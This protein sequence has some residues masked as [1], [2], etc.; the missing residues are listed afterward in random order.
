M[1]SRILSLTVGGKL[2]WFQ[3]VREDYLFHTQPFYPF[4]HLSHLHHPY[5][6]LSFE[7]FWDIC[8]LWEVTCLYFYDWKLMLFIVKYFKYPENGKNN[9]INSTCLLASSRESEHFTSFALVLFS[10]WE[11]KIFW[12][13]LKS[14]VYTCLISSPCFSL[15]DNYHPEFDVCLSVHVITQLSSM[16]TYSY[17]YRY[18][19]LKYL[20]SGL[21]YKYHSATYFYFNL[22]FT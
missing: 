21:Y 3:S 17:I 14:S 15:R 20:V 2:S 16:Y 11:S 6:S 19:A 22:V 4:H 10:F 8:L 12:I 13:E 7:Y 9:I 5:P 1:C 18:C